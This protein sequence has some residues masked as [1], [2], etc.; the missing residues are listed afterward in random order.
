[1]NDNL[2]I[3]ILAAGKSTRMKSSIH[4]VMHKIADLPII[5]HV[6]NL[7]KSLESPKIILVTAPDGEDIRNY[8]QAL[9]PKITHVLQERQLGTGDAAKSAL[10][11]IE[12][13]GNSIILYAD[14]P[15]IQK[16]TLQ[17]MLEAQNDVTVIGFT[18][19][20]ENQ[21]GRLV[22]EGQ[23]LIKIVEFNDANMQ[24]KSIELCNSGIMCIN[25]KV[26]HALLNKLENHNIQGEYYLTDIMEIAS[27]SGMKIGYI[28]A[29]EK[30]VMG[31]NNRSEL[32]EASRAYQALRAKSMLKNGVTLIDKHHVQFSHDTEIEADVVIHP[33]T[34]FGPGVKIKSGAEI[35]SF[36]HIEGATIAEG[37]T[38]GPF[39][40]IRPNSVIGANCKIGN[41]VEVKNTHLAEKTK[42]NHLSYVG[43]A[44]IGSGVNIGAG[45]ITC[46]YDGVAHKYRT[47]IGNNVAIGS[48]SSLIAPIVI[49]DDS[50]VAAGSVLTKNVPKNALAIARTPQQ[51]KEQAAL[52]FRK[53]PK[54]I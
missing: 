38:I 47:V 36:C 50:I 23:K 15:L 2:S 16:E 19:A 37:A 17:K 5:H 11:H 53:R 48:N 54:K 46:N 6:F 3:I 44:T 33:Y 41:F 34:V 45:T 8:L 30:E 31:I 27:K 51:N 10:S 25:N 29:P 18:S 7:A 20:K 39:A 13:S 14:H 52:N 22:T 26:I 24:E 40:R 32:D 49:E 43:D 1:M 21:Y 12:P 4:K 35:K 42:I 28:T 9:N